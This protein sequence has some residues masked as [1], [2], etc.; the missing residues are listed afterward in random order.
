LQLALMPEGRVKVD[1]AVSPEGTAEPVAAKA[2]A[3]D[4]AAGIDAAAG[5][6]ADRPAD[7]AEN[8]AGG[9]N[10]IIT[11]PIR[12]GQ[13]VYAAGGDLIVLA[14]VSTGAEVLADG[15]IHIYGALRGRA[16]AGV[17][18]DTSARIFCQSLEAEL[19]SIAGDFKLH[20]DFRGQWW[21]KPVQVS[22]TDDI[23]AIEALSK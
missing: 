7:S 11:T 18:G 4:A 23:L 12:S 21:K 8:G 20:E 22:L 1:A 5:S 17:R 16:L 15:N 19:I 9:G 14:A 6:G 10:K 13:Q 2:A 3:T